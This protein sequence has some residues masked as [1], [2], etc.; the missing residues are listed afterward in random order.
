[1]KK[2]YISPKQT[3]I[4]M[5]MTA[6]CAGSIQGNKVTLDTSDTNAVG[7]GA[8]LGRDGIFFDEDEE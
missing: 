7:A 1:M 2:Q 3:A 5:K 6:L 8:S 4:V